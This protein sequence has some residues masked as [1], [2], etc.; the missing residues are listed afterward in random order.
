MRLGGDESLAFV[1]DYKAAHKVALEYLKPAV[2]R[3]KLFMEVMERINSSKSQSDAELRGQDK[4]EAL[5]AMAL[6]QVFD[7]MT[8]YCHP[9][10][11]DED[12][13]EASDGDWADDKVSYTAV[14]QLASFCLL[15]LRSEALKGASLDA[16][17][18]KAEATALTCSRIVPPKVAPGTLLTPMSSAA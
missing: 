12:V 17:S 5:I 18:R 9:R 6:T 7:Y 2:A 11:P 14:A 3:E 13:G 16:A 1:Y 10:V 15:S 8:L 4:A